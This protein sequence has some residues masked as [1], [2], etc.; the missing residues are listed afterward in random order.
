MSNPRIRLVRPV[1]DP[2]GLFIRAGQVAQEDLQNFI[3]SRTAPFSIPESLR[4]S[5]FLE[6]LVR[7]ASDTA[8]KASTWDL[9][10]ELTNKIQ[11]QTKR[12]NALR[13]TLGVCAAE[14]EPAH[15]R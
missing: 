6:E 8:V 3:T 11:K 2:L 1:P 10:E 9:P 14:A 5:Q 15:D 7:P 12:L 4:P 13:T